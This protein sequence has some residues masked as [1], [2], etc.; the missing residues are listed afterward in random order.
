MTHKSVSFQVMILILMCV[1]FCTLVGIFW[2]VHNIS[3]NL[4]YRLMVLEQKI[5]YAEIKM[6]KV[7]SVSTSD[8]VKTLADQL[9]IH[10]KENADLKQRTLRMSPDG[11]KTAYYQYKFVTDMSQ[12]GDRD[13]TSLIVT[14]GDTSDVIFQGTFKLS[15]FEWLTNDIIEVGNNCGTGCLQKY[16]VNIHTKKI[17]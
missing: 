14:S 15:G 8:T 16:A 5:S 4:D 3:E 17:H 10:N 13:Y 11:K 1:C 7:A 2:Y 12:L 6:Q 9:A